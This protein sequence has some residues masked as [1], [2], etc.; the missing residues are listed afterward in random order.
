METLGLRFIAE[1][2]TLEYIETTSARNGY[3]ES[4]QGAVI[5]FETFEEAK[6][7]ASEND[8]EVKF[9]QKKDGW[10]L[11]YR[12]GNTAYEEMSI[13]SNYYYGDDY[14]EIYSDKFDG[15]GDFLDEEVNEQFSELSS[16]EEI[17]RF[18]SEKKDLWDKI[19]KM[20]KDEV[21]IINCGEYHETLKIK[22]M[23]FSHDTR[24]TVIGCI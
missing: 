9:F 14:S 1:E 7:L 4:I 18:L 5:G 22:T 2:N 10:N 15:E 6:N 11:W 21:I 20:E 24:T 16:F 23:R 13:S 8:L 19:E 17:E 3:P 12:N